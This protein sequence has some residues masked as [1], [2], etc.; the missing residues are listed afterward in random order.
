[1]EIILQHNLKSMENIEKRSQ[2]VTSEIDNNGSEKKARPK[3]TTLIITFLSILAGIASIVGLLLTIL[4][5]SKDDGPKIQYEMVRVKGGTCILNE[6][7]LGLNGVVDTVVLEDYYIGKYEVTQK[8]WSEIMGVN[9]SKWKKKN[10]PVNNVNLNDISSFLIKLQSVTGKQYRLPSEAEWEYAARG[11]SKTQNYKYSGSN[12]IPDVAWYSSN[13]DMKIHPVGKK[14]PNE[15]GLYDMSGNVWEWCNS[16]FVAK[17][18]SNNSF[19]EDYYVLRGGSF[20][21]T[22]DYSRVSS[23]DGAPP[24]FNA[25]DGGIGFRLVLDVDDD[26]SNY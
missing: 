20:G 8:E 7:R 19:C 13:S 21:L 17:C 24:S 5:L 26:S 14:T 18:T 4:P 22:E 10:H 15:L 1:M 6:S 3:V 25:Y 9:P 11:G 16:L 12:R 23:R 2:T